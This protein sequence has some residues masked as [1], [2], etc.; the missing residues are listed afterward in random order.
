M[1]EQQSE[2]YHLSPGSP[3]LLFSL[4]MGLEILFWESEGTGTRGHLRTGQTAPEAVT[5]LVDKPLGLGSQ[6]MSG[7]VKEEES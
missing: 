2:T 6:W 5:G 7:C 3:A 4:Q 1:I